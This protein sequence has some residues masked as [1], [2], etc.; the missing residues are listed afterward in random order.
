M[1][2]AHVFPYGLAAVLALLPGW[3]SEER[4]PGAP[5]VQ[6]RAAT[7]IERARDGFFYVDAKVNGVS[8]RFLVDTGASIAIISAKDASRIGLPMRLG[9]KRVRT[10]GGAV[11]MESATLPAARIAGRDLIGI[12]AVVSPQTGTSLI[13]QRVLSQFA[14]VTMRGD[15]M[16]FD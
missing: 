7:T 2:S 4:A 6:V 11:S 9:T 10:V 8:V 16:R 12:D 1:P 13:G 3:R 14:S 5:H 15:T